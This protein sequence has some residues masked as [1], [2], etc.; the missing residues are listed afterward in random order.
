VID[1]EVSHAILPAAVYT[2]VSQN[3]L[4]TTFLDTN[5]ISGS[6]YMFRVRSRNEFGYSDYSDS[7]TLLVAFVPQL[8]VPPVTSV[9]A[10][11]VILTWQAP[12]NNGSPITKYLITLRQSDNTYSESSFCNGQLASTMASLSCTIPLSSLTAAPYSL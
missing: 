4:G 6:N 5:L 7:I 12:Y 11:N 8:P 1:Y 2:V 10:D 9:I 3:N